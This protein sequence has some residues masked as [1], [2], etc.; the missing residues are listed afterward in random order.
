MTNLRHILS[1]NLKRLRKQNKISQNQLAERINSAANYISKIESEKQFPSIEM[2]E[3]IAEALSC[4]TLDLFSIKNIQ[5]D[6][7]LF[8]L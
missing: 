5:N 6:I 7:V 2:L 4:D 1:E 8:F 3:K